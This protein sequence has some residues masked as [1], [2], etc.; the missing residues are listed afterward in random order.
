VAEVRLTRE[1]QGDYDALPLPI[2]QRVLLI[3]QRL[4]HWP[5][6]SG[7]KPLRGALKGGHRIRTGAWRV[8]FRVDPQGGEDG[9]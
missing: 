9:S 4:R 2:R 8:L 6:V 7:V 1:A 3:F 5:A